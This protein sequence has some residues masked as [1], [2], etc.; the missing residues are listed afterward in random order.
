MSKSDAREEEKVLKKRIEK[1]E[2]K[3]QLKVVRMPKIEPRNK[4]IMIIIISILLF[5]NYSL[6]SVAALKGRYLEY[7]EDIKSDQKEPL[8]LETKSS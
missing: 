6:I 2:E 7:L 4:W 5:L 8:K 3:G 1:A